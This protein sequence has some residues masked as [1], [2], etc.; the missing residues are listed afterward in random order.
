MRSKESEPQPEGKRLKD[1]LR[2][3]L[4]QGFTAGLSGSVAMSAQITAFMWL[5][6]I[7]RYQYRHGTSAVDTIRF[8]YREGGIF[9]F[10]RGYSFAILNAPLIRFGST[11][12]NKMCLHFLDSLNRDI[13]MW[14][15]TMASASCAALWKVMFTPLDMIQTTLQ[16]GGTGG[17]ADVKAKIKS[18]GIKVLWHGSSA[19]YVS[20]LV[21]NFSWF[22]VYNTLNHRWRDSG[23]GLQTVRDGAIGVLSTLMSDVTT[24]SLEVLKT[25]RQTTKHSVGYLQALTEIVGSDGVLGLVTRGLQVRLI[26][27]CLQGAFFTIVWNG[28]QRRLDPGSV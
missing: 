13:P 1:A 20:A 9:R 19:V 22:C 27:N 18:H 6:T 25:H 26:T 17:R 12:S 8:L 14:T 15:G 4:S 10:Y 23:D 3:A 24:N 28:I 7:M 5:H 11:A 2:E 16:V 21:G